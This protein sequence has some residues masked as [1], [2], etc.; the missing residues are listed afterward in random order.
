M[1]A[2]AE[3]D[4]VSKIAEVGTSAADRRTSRENQDSR[5][6]KVETAPKLGIPANKLMYT[7][8]ELCTYFIKLELWIGPKS[9]GLHQGLQKIQRETSV[10][11]CNVGELRAV[12]P[13]ACIVLDEELAAELVGHLPKCLEN[14]IVKIKANHSVDGRASSLRIMQA[15]KCRVESKTKS[16]GSSLLMKL[17]ARE[18]CSA[19]QLLRG[20]LL[21]VQEEYSLLERM[22]CTPADQ[23]T[24]MHPVLV[25][26]ISV[27][28]CDGCVGPTVM[29]KMAAVEQI[30][31]GDSDALRDVL[32]LLGAE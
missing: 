12:L 2:A 3:V 29:A 4:L 21:D 26:L 27:L 5:K 17:I 13:Q 32:D 15:L 6:P 9:D 14:E 1:D 18:P 24:I 30:K 23:D 20:E 22:G 16:R 7:S 28:E 31:P 11:Q 25:R 19:T 10:N 8:S